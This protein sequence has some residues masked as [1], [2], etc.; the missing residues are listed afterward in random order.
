MTDKKQDPNFEKAYTQIVEF[1][2]DTMKSFASTINFIQSYL[3]STFQSS[4]NEL[5][6]FINAIETN[7]GII[8]DNI[9]NFRS[10]LIK[11]YTERVEKLSSLQKMYEE[12]ND[13]AK[14]IYTGKQR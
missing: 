5:D 13:K 8:K 10:F 2:S 11:Q 7:K 4:S 12:L 3:D 14:K 1:K 9:N 6:N